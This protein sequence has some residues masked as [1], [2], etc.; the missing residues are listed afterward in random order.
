MD[1]FVSGFAAVIGRPNVGKSSL[2]NTLVGHK[3]CIVSE[4]PQ[5]TRNRIMGVVNGRG[6]QL[7]LLDTPGLQTP[8]NRL[9]H[10]MQGAVKHALTDINA[11][12]CVVEAHRPLGE[13]DEQALLLAKNAGAPV[14]VVQNKCDL[15][16]AE[17]I[18]AQ[19]QAIKEFL[20]EASF[21][22]VS[23]LTGE[24]LSGLLS[25]LIGLL[26]QGPAYFP[27][28]EWCDKPE[29]FLCAE[30]I[31][32]KVLLFLREEV[33]HG[34]GVELERFFEREDGVVEIHAVIHCERQSHKGILIG[35][36][37]G[38]LKKIG[39]SAREELEAFFGTK[40]FLQIFVRVR[41]N[42]RNSPTALKDLGFD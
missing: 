12:L 27:E 3:V 40:V 7:V 33:P 17:Q 22:P 35:K 42:W 34:V 32:E 18:S 6:Y 20:L 19:A 14:L 2:V 4:K 38:M 37:G 9:G 1:A 41:E 23:A 28:D 5:T 15:A 11:V 29:D 21:F 31:R 16:T 25:C 8:K 10:Y 36:G 24:G 13:R 39:S 26:P 30:I